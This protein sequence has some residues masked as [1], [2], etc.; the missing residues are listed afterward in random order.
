M[1]YAT[2]QT[3]AE[4]R[5]EEREYIENRINVLETAIKKTRNSFVIQRLVKEITELEQRLE[6]LY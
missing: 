2:M 1:N 6:D 3:N 5:Q 4:I